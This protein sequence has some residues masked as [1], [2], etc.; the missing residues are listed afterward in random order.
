MTHRMA[1]QQHP[2]PASPLDPNHYTPVDLRID[3]RDGL[4]IKWADGQASHYA[5]AFLRKH[6]PCAACRSERTS[7]TAAP[8]PPPGTI[9]LT[10]LP[11][12]IDRAAEFT[13]AKLVGNYAL[14]ITWADGHSTGIYEF[15]Y[16]R[17][18]GPAS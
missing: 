11:R 3:R 14:Q 7:P 4:Y 8:P 13:D 18:I 6:C 2:D 17:A 5:L 12:N 9:P 10:V 15:R 1:D 16:L